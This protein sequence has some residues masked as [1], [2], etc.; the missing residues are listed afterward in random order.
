MFCSEDFYKKSMISFFY[1]YSCFSFVYKMQ[2]LARKHPS[3]WRDSLR[4]SVYHNAF[5][6]TAQV[7]LPSIRHYAFDRT[8]LL[9]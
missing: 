1:T 8:D 4:A 2:K 9:E 6:K 7:L 5:F 3:S